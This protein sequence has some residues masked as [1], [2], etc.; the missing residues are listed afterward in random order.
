MVSVTEVCHADEAKR[1]HGTRPAEPTPSVAPQG[2][3]SAPWWWLLPWIVVFL[4]V[5]VAREPG[6]T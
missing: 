2:L 4:A 3:L 5:V 6:V 1:R